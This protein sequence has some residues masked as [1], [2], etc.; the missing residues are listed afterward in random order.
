MTPLLIYPAADVRD[1][2][3]GSKTAVGR[4]SAVGW[5]AARWSYRQIFRISDAPTTN[6]LL[7]DSG[8]C[9]SQGR[10]AQGL[11]EA[12]STRPRPLSVYS[13]AIDALL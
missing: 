9:A 12:C 7:T 3:N 13:G 2:S 4:T 5:E 8:A 6:P 1:R 11:R 10:H